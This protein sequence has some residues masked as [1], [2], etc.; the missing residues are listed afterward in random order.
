MQ[1]TSVQLHQAVG[2]ELSSVI[3]KGKAYKLISL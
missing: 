3:G 1:N 2:Y